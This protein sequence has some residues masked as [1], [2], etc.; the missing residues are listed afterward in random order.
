M[1]LIKIVTLFV[2]TLTLLV[3]LTQAKEPR[4][5]LSSF[6]FSEDFSE[7]YADISC[8]KVENFKPTQYIIGA[9]EVHFWDSESSTYLQLITRAD[10]KGK[11][12]YINILIQNEYADDGQLQGSGTGG[13]YVD[14][15]KLYSYTY[16]DTGAAQT[17]PYGVERITYQWDRKA[18]R[19]NIVD[20]LFSM[21][22]NYRARGWGQSNYILTESTSPSSVDKEEMFLQLFDPYLSRS[23]DLAELFATQQVYLRHATRD[24][25]AF[26]VT[27]TPQEMYEK[28]VWGQ[29]ALNLVAEAQQ[30]I[31][32]P[33]HEMLLRRQIAVCSRGNDPMECCAEMPDPMNC[34]LN[35]Y[36]NK[37]AYK[38]PKGFKPSSS[39]Q[40]A[41]IYA[42]GGYYSPGYTETIL[43]TTPN[44]QGV[45]QYI[46]FRTYY[47][48]IFGD[49]PPEEHRALMHLIGGY[50]LNEDKLTIYQ[51]W[52]DGCALEQGLA[53]QTKEFQ[54]NA[55]TS[56]FEETQHTQAVV[57]KDAKTASRYQSLKSYGLISDSDIIKT[58]IELPEQAQT[59]LEPFIAEGR[60]RNQD[61]C[62]HNG[63]SVK[64]QAAP[65]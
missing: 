36:D 54:W 47:P 64:T 49:Y 21:D 45:Q 27:L 63:L 53:L 3:P 29:D 26:L 56:R 9:Q 23:M 31:A 25:D 18:S 42:L 7:E 10:A 35:R 34:F 13:Y 60:K 14:G 39:I 48:A 57:K 22:S 4:C 15:D 46:P 43:I 17:H 24:I 51:Y 62:R 16:W 33:I 65:E 37:I 20:Y 30:R 28:F 44:K 11:S 40:D 38:K 32:Q 2:F 55:N 6:N 8:Q 50:T 61:Y 59:V 52:V 58:T 5:D 41:R 19:Y 12:Q 1:K